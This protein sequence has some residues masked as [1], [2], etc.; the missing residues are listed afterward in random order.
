MN[1]I[2]Q[3]K[4]NNSGIRTSVYDKAGKNAAKYGNRTFT[5]TKQRTVGNNTYVL[6]TNHNQNTPIGW[7]KI[8]D[9]NI[10]I[11][12]L[13][14]ELQINIALTVKPRFIFNPLGY[15]ATTI[16]TSKFISTTYI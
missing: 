12:E 15:N 7:Y 2:G 4:V 5:I 1:K 3:V 11:M 14:I 16:G 9:V 10:K 6:L 8:K 13:K